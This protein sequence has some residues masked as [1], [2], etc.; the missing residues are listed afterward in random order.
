MNR[1]ESATREA[2]RAIHR[3]VTT[4]LWWDLVSGLV[5]CEGSDEVF[6]PLADPAD[7]YV[8]EDALQLSVHYKKTDKGITVIQ[9]SCPH[10][11]GA[12]MHTVQP[13]EETIV[14]RM[15]A[16][17]QFAALCATMTDEVHHG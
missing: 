9:V 14:A 6:A 15:H 7:A 1:R 8:V 17:T 11:G 12:I 3:D 10:H 16:I 2:A 4:W 13:H 5:A